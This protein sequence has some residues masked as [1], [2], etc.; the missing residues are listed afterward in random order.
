MGEF[1]IPSVENPGNELD[2]ILADAE[3]LSDTELQKTNFIDTVKELLA[4][5]G[6]VELVNK[7]EKGEVN[8]ELDATNFEQLGNLAENATKEYDSTEIML[9][10]AETVANRLIEASK[11]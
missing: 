11:K 6:A 8:L 4:K 5:K 9:K 7:I 1:Y 3:K 10:R 2:K